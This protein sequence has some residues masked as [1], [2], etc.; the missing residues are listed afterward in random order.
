MCMKLPTTA[1]KGPDL[2]FSMEIIKVFCRISYT[3]LEI[4]QKI[5][6]TGS[7]SI[8]YIY[9]HCQHTTSQILLINIKVHSVSRA[10]RGGLP[11]EEGHRRGRSLGSS[12]RRGELEQMGLAMPPVLG[13]LDGEKKEVK[14]DGS[15]R[16]L[17][18]RMG[19]GYVVS[20]AQHVSRQLAKVLK[21]DAGDLAPVNGATN[22]ILIF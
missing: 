2:S 18:T 4:F 9:P 21:N 11:P 20:T 17:Q 14:K 22:S 6:L 3:L 15:I 12:K 16:V 7:F 10:G 5:A 8:N 19:R 13:L 1:G